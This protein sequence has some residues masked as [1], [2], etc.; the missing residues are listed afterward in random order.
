MAS[1][2]EHLGQAT[3]YGIWPPGRLD[4]TGNLI[5]FIDNI[6]V[7]MGLIVLMNNY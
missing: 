2:L 4:R 5:K 7:C 6:D 1:E 3:T